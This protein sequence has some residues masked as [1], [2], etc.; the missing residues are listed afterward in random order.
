[1]EESF[2]FPTV[3]ISMWRHMKTINT[4]FEQEKRVSWL[5]LTA[6]TQTCL[7]CFFCIE[8]VLLSAS[9]RAAVLQECSVLLDQKFTSN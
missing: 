3:P 9:P 6:E 7:S 2:I 1:M 5:S 4:V 8:L